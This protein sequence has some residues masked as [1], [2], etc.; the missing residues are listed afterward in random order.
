MEITPRVHALRIPFRVPT[1]PGK[2]IDR[3]V[4][5][6]VLLGER[7][8][9]VDT[10]VA[11]SDTALLG[12]VGELGRPP[13]SVAHI[14]LTH[15]HAD[16]IGSARP[17]AERTGA[18][19]YADLA[20]CRWIEDIDVQAQERPIPGFHE[21]VAGSVPVDEA[22]VDGQRLELDPS[23]HVRVLSTPGHSPGST[24][25]LVEEERVLITGDAIP[26]VGDMPVY[27]DPVQS[28]RSIVRLASIDAVDV[29]L[30][31]WDAPHRGPDA[32][33]AMQRGEAL[34][35]RIHDAVAAAVPDREPIDGIE[36]CRRV[37][38]ALDLPETMVNPLVAR[39]L[40]GHLR[41]PADA[42]ANIR[43]STPPPSRR[44]WLPWRS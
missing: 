6:F 38:P 40:L 9:L 35:R 20:E 39:T 10:G 32:R 42:L 27:D 33:A 7:T 37:L 28:V 8:W 41:V 34:I 18:D 2:G 21:L 19:V 26:V 16:H 13:E 25:F 14:L 12:L 43:P 1:G 24:S 17:L 5:A 23:L 22:L 15:G 29:A 3:F 31:S 36:L 4:H 44:S 30:S 11:G